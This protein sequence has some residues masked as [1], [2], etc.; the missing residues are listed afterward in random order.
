[1]RTTVQ[2]KQKQKSPFSVQEI[3]KVAFADK[4]RSGND[5]SV[6]M[7]H[8]VGDCRIEKIAMDSLEEFFK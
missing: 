1:M 6:I 4:K 5:I 7:V 2:I 3:S 8:G